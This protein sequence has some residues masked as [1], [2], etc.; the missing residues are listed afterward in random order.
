MGPFLDCDEEIRKRKE[1]ASFKTDCSEKELEKDKAQGSSKE[2]KEM[3]LREYKE[4]VPNTPE[5]R[6]LYLKSFVVAEM[7]KK[8]DNCEE[9]QARFEEAMQLFKE[10]REY[11]RAFFKMARLN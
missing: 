8:Y 11:S 4:Y 10:S 6:A 5:V 7:A 2:D 1:N 3:V 9:Q